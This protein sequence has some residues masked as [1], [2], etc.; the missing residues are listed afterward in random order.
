MPHGT[1][2]PALTPTTG[3]PTCPG[4]LNPPDRV[5]TT[6]P[7][8]T[9]R[10]LLIARRWLFGSSLLFSISVWS[11]ESLQNVVTAGVFRANEIGDRGALS[12]LTPA[13]SPLG[14]REPAWPLS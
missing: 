12:P 10:N 3:G 14:E 8:M 6:P 9:N 13:L 4:R 2:A 5:R 11:L 1:G 7:C